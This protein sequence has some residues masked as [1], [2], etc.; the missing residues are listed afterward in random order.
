[1]NGLKKVVS[2]P[3]Q[4]I[5][6][7]ISSSLYLSNH[8]STT[9]TSNNLNVVKISPNLSFRKNKNS[10]LQDFERPLVIVYGWLAAKLKHIL[11]YGDFYLDKGFDVL[12]VKVTPS[13]L[14]R[15]KY[16][17]KTID[18]IYD[19]IHSGKINLQPLLIHGFSVGGY[20]Y[21][22]TLFKFKNDEKNF[23]TI[24][25]RLRGQIFDSAVDLEGLPR[26]TSRAVTNIKILQ[27]TLELTLNAY[28]KVFDKQ[29]THYYKR[30]S[31]IFH[32]NYFKTP[33]LM[34]YSTI[35]KIGISSS[36]DAVIKN[37]QRQN[38]P[39]MIKCWD[40]S[41]HV[42]HFLYHQMEYIDYLNK[43]LEQI[44]LNQINV[45]VKEKQLN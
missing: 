3:L 29:V 30:S 37:W 35:D 4:D 41:P 24:S 6:Q 43:F 28:L 36:I 13:Q 1:M 10:Q 11:K 25:K 26:G 42:G 33:S 20:L 45:K 39:V 5:I 8:K 34:L 7:K 14:L 44:Q 16:V 31:Q 23:E 40:D 19:F 12:H 9:S 18:T 21:G 38:I 32:E 15:P 22:E 17:H 2:F 27:K